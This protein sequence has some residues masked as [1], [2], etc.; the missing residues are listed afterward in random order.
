MVFYIIQN[1]C[2]NC[3]KF[4]ASCWKSYI[5]TANYYNNYFY[6]SNVNSNNLLAREVFMSISEY[7]L[8]PFL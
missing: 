3:F 8:D 1:L 6:N 7:A 5:Y 2:E 4:R